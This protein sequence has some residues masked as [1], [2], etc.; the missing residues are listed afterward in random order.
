MRMLT[1]AAA[2]IALHALAQVADAQTGGS[3]FCMQTAAGARCVFA[4]MGECERARTTSASGQ[5]I[6]H[7]ASAI[8]FA[9]SNPIAAPARRSIQTFERR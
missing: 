3:P 9:A 2:I 5:C 1:A 7:L 6:S 8:S 4:T